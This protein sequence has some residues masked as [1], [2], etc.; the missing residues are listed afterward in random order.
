MEQTTEITPLELAQSVERAWESFLVTEEG[1]APSNRPYC[2]AS[3]YHPCTR[4]QVLKMTHGETLPAWDTGAL[5]RFRRG[6]DR[7][8]DLLVDLS[9]IG[10]NATPQFESIGGQERLTIQDRKGRTVIVGKVDTRLKFETG[11]LAP[12]EIKSWSPNLTARIRTFEDLFRSVWTRKGAFQLLCY[13]LGQGEEV[14]FLI[15]DMPGIPRLIPVELNDV[16]L[17]RAEKFLSQAEETMDHQEA[18]TLPDF[19]TAD[20]GECKRCPFFGDACQPPLDYGPGAQVLM[21]PEL[22]EM[23]EE[24][25]QVAA[26]GRQFAQLDKKAKKRLRGIERGICGPF[27]ITGKWEAST[28]YEIPPEIKQ[29]YRQVNPKGRFLVEVEKVG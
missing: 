5:A 2:Y 16:N 29:K 21:D 19:Y 10:R 9:R 7:E 15:L 13:L 18:G 1:R 26:A 11:L 3:D 24:R 12:A 8:R 27:M 6:R 4:Y 14:G 28:R 25:E 23:L 20:P 17:Q 22:E